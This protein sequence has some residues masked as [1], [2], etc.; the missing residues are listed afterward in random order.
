MSAAGNTV[1]VNDQKEKRK[2]KKK[3]L[4]N[5]GSYSGQDM[6]RHTTRTQKEYNRGKQKQI[7]APQ[8]KPGYIQKAT[9]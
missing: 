5:T 7:N 2:E 3:N 4:S 8:T 6:S 9:K 1:P